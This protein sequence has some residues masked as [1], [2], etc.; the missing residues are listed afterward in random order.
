LKRRIGEAERGENGERIET[1]KLRRAE[2]Q[3]KEMAKR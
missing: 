1:K 2:E 3:I